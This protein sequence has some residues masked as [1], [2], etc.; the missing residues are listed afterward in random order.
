MRYFWNGSFKIGLFAELSSQSKVPPWPRK[1][2]GRWWKMHLQAG[3][4]VLEVITFADSGSVSS[5]CVR[6]WIIYDHRISICYMLYSEECMP[7]VMSHRMLH[8]VL[9]IVSLFFWDIGFMIV[10]LGRHCS[11][12]TWSQHPPWA[13]RRA[14]VRSLGLLDLFG[15]RCAAP[16]CPVGTKSWQLSTQVEA[17]QRDATVDTGLHKWRGDDLAS[18]YDKRFKECFFLQY[19]V[20]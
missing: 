2:C 11:R 19:V 4:K 7:Y 14:G 1:E 8:S 3:E 5:T 18:V 15:V 12:T 10:M 16:S 17:V 6:S 9:N 20:S 13:F